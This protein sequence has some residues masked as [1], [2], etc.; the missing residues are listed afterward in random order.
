M[1]V[2]NDTKILKYLNT[3]SKE[4]LIELLIEYSP[5]S[6]K[7]EI[8]LRDAS[9]DVLDIRLNAIISS[10]NMDLDDEE[11]LYNPEKFQKNISESIENLSIFVNQRPSEIFEILFDL[12][13]KLEDK[14]E[15]GYLWIDNY[16]TEEYFDFDK[17]SDEMM[18]LINCIKDTKVQLKL[19]MK[20]GE[21]AQGSGYLPFSY[22]ALGLEDKQ[23]LLAYFNAKSALPFYHYIEALL[24]FEEKEKFLLA[25]D[26]K[27]VYEILIKIYLENNKKYLAIEVIENLLKEEFDLK[28]VEKLLTLTNITTERLRLFISKMIETNSYGGFNFIV[29][30]FKKLDNIKELER[31][32]K[33]KNSSQYYKYLEKEQRIDEM[34]ALLKALPNNR[35]AFLKKHKLAYKEEAIDFFNAQITKNLKSTGDTHY[36]NIAGALWQLKA[37][38]EEEELKI[39]VEALK[40]EYKRRRNFVAILV[41]RFG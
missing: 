27:G 23:P 24:S 7:K 30:G 41:T 35:E 13:E 38:I 40:F 15:N 33:D 8:I 14:Y 31:L 6:L 26:L 11:L 25:H 34:Y 20:F 39:K 22:D 32:W 37:L 9:D 21:V 16:H 18:G 3:L 2:K 28:Y 36:H 29:D 17:L 10:L 19:F 4:K 1:P 12:A 5:E